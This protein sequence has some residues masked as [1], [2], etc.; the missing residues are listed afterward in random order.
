MT[1][2][3]VLNNQLREASADGHLDIVKRLV[4]KG[5]D[6][7]TNDGHSLRLASYYGHLEI[8]KYLVNEGVDIR[9]GGNYPLRYAIRNNH[10]EVVKYLESIML[11]EKRLKCIKKL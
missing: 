11:K 4:S 10:S 3:K 1:T 6:V 9:T 7:N 5:A 2:Q 8:V